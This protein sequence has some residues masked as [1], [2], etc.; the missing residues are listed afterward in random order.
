MSREFLRQSQTQ[1][2]GVDRGG[3]TLHSRRAAVQC[4]DEQIREQQHLDT[5]GAK[6]VRKRVMLLLCPG[7]PRQSVEEQGV[8]VSRGESSQFGTGPVQDHRTQCPD[9][10]VDPESCHAQHR[11]AP[12]TVSTCAPANAEWR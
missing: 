2:P 12:R 10:G 6:Q 7:Q 5:A 11:I 9:L 4:L 8:V 3:D 1:P